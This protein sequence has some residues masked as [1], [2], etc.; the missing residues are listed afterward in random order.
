ML[1]YHFSMRSAWSKHYK[2]M[3]TIYVLNFVSKSCM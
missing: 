1:N 2:S 3:I